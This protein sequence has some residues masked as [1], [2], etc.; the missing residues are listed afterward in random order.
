MRASYRVS[1]LTDAAYNIF[2][3]RLVRLCEVVNGSEKNNVPIIES[4]EK[5]RVLI[6]FQNDTVKTCTNYLFVLI[7]IFCHSEKNYTRR[8]VLYLFNNNFVVL[9]FGRRYCEET[10]D[11]FYDRDWMTLLKL[12]VVTY[13]GMRKEITNRRPSHGKWSEKKITDTGQWTGKRCRT[14]K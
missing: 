6:G 12:R 8:A 4:A 5:Q 11:T 2:F 10:S 1:S 9:A 13:V 3:N 7:K 14:T